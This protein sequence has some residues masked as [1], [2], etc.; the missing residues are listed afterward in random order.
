MGR[1]EVAAAVGAESHWGLP[2]HDADAVDRRRA[3]VRP[4]AETV[5][6]ALAPERE[7]GLDRARK[8]G[9]TAAE[10]TEVLATLD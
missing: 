6:A 3:A 8:A 5:A 10:E 1:P 2:S 7:L 9:L 4:L